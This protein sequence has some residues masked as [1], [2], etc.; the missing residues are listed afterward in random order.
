MRLRVS[1]RGE[2]RI[3]S[4]LRVTF[5]DRSDAGRKLGA[6]LARFN[7]TPSVVVLGVP[8]G[9]VPVAA[10]V[11]RTLDAP[12]DIFVVRKLGVPH[13]EELA[14]G[15]IAS[16]GVQ[17]LDASVI[18]HLQVPGRDIH[19]VIEREAKELERREVAY[20]GARRASDV[21]NRVVILVD[22][23]I[24]TGSSMRAAVEA[25]RRLGPSRIIV[26]VPVAAPDS[27]QRLAKVADEVV[28]LSAPEDFSAVGEWYA[29]FHGTSDEEVTA[30][31]QSAAE[32]IADRA[33]EPR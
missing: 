23:G 30:A 24:A 22:D 13:H 28:C 19:A 32:R 20:R 31:L 14:F 27:I 4:R 17:I 11:A 29:D 21:S 33:N 8:R 5:R 18:E 7:K 15:A 25:L 1:Q 6:Q 2:I 26:A 12:L 3:P 16:G 10:E 9:G